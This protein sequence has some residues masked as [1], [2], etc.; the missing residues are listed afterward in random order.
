[1][2][3]LESVSPLVVAWAVSLGLGGLL[4]MLFLAGDPP[5]DEPPGANSPAAVDQRPPGP[6]VAAPVASEPG[7]PGQD[8]TSV[9]K[10]DTDGA[11]SAGGAEQVV[12][13]KKST[14]APPPPEPEPQPARPDPVAVAKPN[15]PKQPMV[16]QSKPKPEPK[17]RPARE[18][19][20]ALEL[21]IVRYVHQKPVA[22]SAVIREIAQLGGIEVR[23]DK[24]LKALKGLNG[25]KGKDRLDRKV[26]LDLGKTTVGEILDAALKM[27]GLTRRVHDGYVLIVLPANGADP[28][29]T[30]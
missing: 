27:V 5:E 15:P 19:E 4:L 3:R 30:R 26:Q 12:D 25:L 20:A 22:V 11:G 29:G 2:F 8:A 13:N 18:I 17:P 16:P 9:A 7:N 23:L 21:P 14:A 6:A 1:M 24:A 28:R 10:S